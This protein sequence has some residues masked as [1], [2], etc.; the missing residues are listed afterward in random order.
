ML[1]I[2]VI[3]KNWFTVLPV[4][5]RDTGWLSGSVIISFPDSGKPKVESTSRTVAPILTSFVS[6]VLGFVINSFLIV[7]C[8]LMSIE[9]PESILTVKYLP[10]P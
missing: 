5:A 7:P 9:Y 8:T 3:W 1:L 2:P 4:Y 10:S 6:L